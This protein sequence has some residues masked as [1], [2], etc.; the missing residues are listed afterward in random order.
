MLEND[1]FFPGTYGLSKAQITIMLNEKKQC[2]SRQWSKRDFCIA[3]QL[4][5]YGTKALDFVG[6]NLLPMPVYSTLRKTF[7]FMHLTPGFLKPATEYLARTLPGKSP[8]KRIC[9]LMFDEMGITN[10]GM[11]DKK[12]DQIIGL[13]KKDVL[14]FLKPCSKIH[15]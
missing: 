3:M 8:F 7:G 12:L 11:H 1:T 10:K 6:K 5:C 14:S 13:N 4:R 2:G 15:A 9:T